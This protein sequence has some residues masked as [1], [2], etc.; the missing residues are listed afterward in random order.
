MITPGYSIAAISRQGPKLNL[1]F[2]SAT[3]DPKIT[4][5]RSGNTATVINSTGSIA[6]VAANTP[7][8]NYNPNTLVCSGLLI[9][10]ARTNSLRNNTMQG[11]VAGSPGTAPT[12]WINFTS[13]TS[14]IQ[15]SI[16]AVGTEAGITYVDVNFAGTATANA[17]IRYDFDAVTA[18][19]ATIG[20]T[21]TASSYLRLISGSAPNTLFNIIE[22][23]GAGAIL[24]SGLSSTL[25]LSAA[26]LINSR[27]TY[28]YTTTNAST[29][30]IQ[31]GF[32][33]GVVN[34][35]TYNFT[36]RFGLPQLELGATSSSAI[37][38]SSGAVTRNADVAV[39]TGSD[40]SSW[41]NATKGTFR[42][43]AISVASGSRPILALDDNTANNSIVISTESTAPTLKVFNTSVEIAN[44]TAGTIVANT[45]MFTYI[46]YDA[47]F[48]GI[49]RPS[50]RQVDSTGK[51]PFVDRLRIGVNQAGI[52]FNNTIQQIQFWE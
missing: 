29:A 19:A 6:D 31:L 18:I 37:K 24:A 47:N 45:A 38:T 10:E 7:R 1:N 28:T 36:I 30:F 8:F 21:W 12:N 51:V 22:R 43:D 4:F 35:T 9:E 23:S 16:S 14:G 41:Y 50:A 17:S 26:N 5:T 44:V 2:T 3:L 11:A 33:F 20:Q 39:I 27:N 52:Y 13:L 25:T 48:F 42:V 40:F 34:G 49:A 46:S 15:A 32:R